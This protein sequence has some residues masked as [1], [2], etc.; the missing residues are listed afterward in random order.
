VR[1]RTG[2]WLLI[3][4][5]VATAVLLVIAVVIAGR[6]SAFPPLPNPNGY[7]LIVKAGGLISGPVGDFPTLSESELRDLMATNAEVLATLRHALSLTCLVPTEEAITNYAAALPQ[8]ATFKALAQLLAAEGRLAELEGRP[9]DAARSYAEAMRLGNEISR[10]GYLIHRL[11]GVALEA[12]GATRLAPLVPKLSAE[13]ARALASELDRIDVEGVTWEEVSRNEGRFSR[14]EL[15]RVP[16]LVKTIVIWWQ[17]RPAR[18]KAKVR[19]ELAVAHIRLLA[20]ELGLRC[21]EAEAGQAPATLDR[22]VPKY[23]SRVPMDPFSGQPLVYQA[24]G[25]NWLLYS[26]GPDRVDNG[27]QSAGRGGL[28]GDVLYTSPW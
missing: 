13:Q 27:G 3:A 4:G 2:Q 22:L 24:Q 18:E 21:F 16:N 28:K 9:G 10:G 17:S 7:D 1:I 20:T 14:Y 19:H 25:T 26:I 5:V 8:L 6:T 23:L 12:I 11:V 15:R